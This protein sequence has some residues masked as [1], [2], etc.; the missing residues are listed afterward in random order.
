MAVL[1]A[2]LFLSNQPSQIDLVKIWHE[3]RTI[4][5]YVSTVDIEN[6]CST[7]VSEK[8]STLARILALSSFFFSF[9]FIYFLPFNFFHFSRN[10]TVLCFV[11]Y[12]RSYIERPEFTGDTFCVIFSTSNI[13]VPQVFFWLVHSMIWVCLKIG[14]I[15]TSAKRCHK[16]QI[17][18]TYLSDSQ[19]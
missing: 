7:M 8:G 11:L 13:L 19:P 15:M 16:F 18:S 10:G 14:M 5:T 2:L 1:L 3:V 6:T 4:L 9:L 17:W 12:V